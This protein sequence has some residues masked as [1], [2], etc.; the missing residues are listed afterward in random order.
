MDPVN[1]PRKKKKT[2]TVCC[3]HASMKKVNEAIQ[4]IRDKD[5]AGVPAL[6]EA[7]KN[8]VTTTKLNLSWLNLGDSGAAALAEALK[9]NCT[10]KELRLGVNS[11]GDEGAAALAEAHGQLHADR[12]VPARRGT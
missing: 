7:L 11:I 4:L 5:P 6:C 3:V 10:L 12:A 1:E 2:I 9:V 8:D